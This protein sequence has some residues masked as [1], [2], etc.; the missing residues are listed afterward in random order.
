MKEWIVLASAVAAAASVL[1]VVA[2]SGSSDD[3]TPL[4][5]NGPG[6]IEG[7]VTGLD[8]EP[9]AGMR[10]AIVSGTASF[11]EIASET[12]DVGLYQIAGVPPGTFQVAVH[13]RQGERIGVES[14]DVRSGETSTLNFLIST[15][16]G[17]DD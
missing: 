14:I 16:E 13:D 12:T 15:G 8:G 9:V 10:I 2:C 17:D 1:L 6:G 11:P 7:T 5:H 3:A 4:G